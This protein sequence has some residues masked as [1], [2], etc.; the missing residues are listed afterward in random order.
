MPV[1]LVFQKMNN[2]F[3][4]VREQ[5]FIWRDA[6][7]QDDY[8]TID[9]ETTAIQSLSTGQDISFAQ[10]EKDVAKTQE[11]LQKKLESWTPLGAN[12]FLK[13]S[14]YENT[15]DLKHGKWAAF[16]ERTTRMFTVNN[17]KTK[18]EWDRLNKEEYVL[19]SVVEELKEK[20]DDAEQR[21]ATV[22]D[23][24]D[25]SRQMRH[26]FNLN[27]FHPEEIIE[28]GKVGKLAEGRQK[29]I[30][31]LENRLTKVQAK[32]SK[33]ETQMV[34]RF[35]GHLGTKKN[36][37][38]FLVDN[39]KSPEEAEKLLQEMI[40][41]KDYD[42]ESKFTA[43]DWQQ[44]TSIEQQALKK[45]VRSFVT[46]KN[47]KQAL[48]LDNLKKQA[49]QINQRK[50]QF[51]KYAKAQP[52]QVVELKKIKKLDD[53]G[54][55]VVLQNK[56]RKYQV[57]TN[58]KSKYTVYLNTE[59]DFSGNVQKDLVVFNQITKK[60]ENYETSKHQVNVK[61]GLQDII[62]KNEAQVKKQEKEIQNLKHEIKKKNDAKT[63]TTDNKEI[64]NIQ[65]IIGDLTK[66]LKAKMQEKVKLK[67]QNQKF[68]NMI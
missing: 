53:Q 56:K 64:I 14:I 24:I 11:V 55:E 18:A 46:N 10:A 30:N 48:T 52:G 68:K 13:N 29:Q 66:D 25:S 2:N 62:N 9:D 17:Q 23:I 61:K 50:T 27:I 58:V 15:P 6:P 37:I 1:L 32:K 42:I 40:D 54:K 34:D 35:A 16:S 12:M 19:Q 3:F 47:I 51:R 57:L 4:F 22:R 26:A 5:R 41:K 67:E 31:N 49:D 60:W 20:K 28:R 7:K 63:Q 43:E 33:L 38:K 44:I 21:A 45:Y 8:E 39:G 36:I 65:T 59:K